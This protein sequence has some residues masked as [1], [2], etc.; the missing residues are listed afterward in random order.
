MRRCAN[1]SLNN[2]MLPDYQPIFQKYNNDLKPLI[3]EIEGR[4][5]RFSQPL[6]LNLASVYDY[7]S[8]SAADDQDKDFCLA[9][10][11]GY[12]DLCISQSYMC[13]IYAIKKDLDAFEKSLGK[14]G[15]RKLNSGHFIGKYTKLKKNYSKLKKK[16]KH[17]DE[18]KALP[19]FKEAYDVVT[20]M[21]RMMNREKANMSLIQK[22]S[23]S[24]ISVAVKWALSI[25]IS[26]LVGL[27]VK[28]YFG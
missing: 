6:L 12:V 19:L 25:M 23:S 26:V 21:E 14:K 10:A 1:L 16:A 8:I 9:E 22:E 13:L 15:L 27:V 7:M 20:E 17:M 4:L 3:S 24:W 2:T 5:E 11:D 28:M 18:R